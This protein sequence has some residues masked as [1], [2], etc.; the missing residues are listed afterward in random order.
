ML[1]PNV[2]F[3][4]ILNQNDIDIC[5]DNAE[6]FGNVLYEYQNS[7]D[8]DWIN[9]L[10]IIQQMGFVPADADSLKNY[11]QMLLNF[12]VPDELEVFSGR[13]GW[14]SDGHRKFFTIL[15]G[16]YFLNFKQSLLYLEEDNFNDIVNE[17]LSLFN[18]DDLEIINNNYAA[19][20]K[21]Y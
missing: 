14:E 15:L 21:F 6:E 9:Y 16:A 7:K 13:I 3:S 17:M 19:I 4:Q 20:I 8:N 1:I 11:F 5:A 12:K 10:E 2:L 18:E